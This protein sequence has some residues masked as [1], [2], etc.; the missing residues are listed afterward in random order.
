MASKTVL[1]FKDSN[2]QESIS[3]SDKPVLVDF[4]AQWC[5]P[6]LQIGPMIE[7]LANEYQDKLVVGKLNIDENQNIPMEFNVRSI[8]TLLIFKNGVVVEKH[9]GSLPKSEL[10]KKIEAHVN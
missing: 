7:E 9:V 10:K 5:G 8:P 6:C 1:E 2:F 4:W 3:Q